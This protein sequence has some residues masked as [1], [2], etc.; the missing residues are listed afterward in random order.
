MLSLFGASATSILLW[1]ITA[2]IITL[3]YGMAG[4]ATL[5]W[6][7]DRG[8]ISTEVGARLN[9]LFL[10]SWMLF[11]LF[12]DVRFGGSWILNICLPLLNFVF[13]A[14]ILSVITQ[15]PD[16]S[17]SFFFFG[18]VEKTFFEDLL[19]LSFILIGL[20]TIFFRSYVAVFIAATLGWGWVSSEQLASW[21]PKKNMKILVFKKNFNVLEI[22][23]FFLGSCIGIIAYLIPLNL[24]QVL[25]PFH[26][27]FDVF[28]LLSTGFI[29]VALSTLIYLST[30]R[31]WRKIT[32]TTGMIFVTL[33]I[34]GIFGTSF[35]ILNIEG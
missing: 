5:S 34:D 4:Y 25:K 26:D 12:Y 10:A 30:P 33:I 17:S 28:L 1:N 29:L 3:I 14:Y 18:K 7:H 11:W 19:I 6:L 2:T 13:A 24:D 21:F 31:G 27:S 35:I 8:W 20:G 15:D 32:I 16:T 22:I 9:H 23:G